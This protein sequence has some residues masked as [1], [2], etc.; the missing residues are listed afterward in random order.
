[1][2]KKASLFIA[3]IMLFSLCFNASALADTSNSDEYMYKTYSI[4]REVFDKKDNNLGRV[5]FE[6]KFRYNPSLGTATC[7]TASNSVIYSSNPAKLSTSHKVLNLRP[8]LGGAY[9][10]VKVLKPSGLSGKKI[11]FLISIDPNGEI[12]FKEVVSK[13]LISTPS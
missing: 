8:D 4:S 9:G 6:F 13:K 11:R 2:V 1:M 12:S 10:E 5:R 3:I 7:L